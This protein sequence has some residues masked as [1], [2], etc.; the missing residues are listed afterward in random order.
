MDDLIS[1]RSMVVNTEHDSDLMIYI[2][3]SVLSVLN[4]NCLTLKITTQN[5]KE[6][7][8]KKNS[9]IFTTFVPNRITNEKNG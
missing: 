5:T 3:Y 6:K 7:K 2:V 1:K 8:T 9:I 4:Y